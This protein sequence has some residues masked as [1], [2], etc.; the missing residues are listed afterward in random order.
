MKPTY[1]L[2]FL[3]IF[4]LLTLHVA[5]QK[6]AEVRN[7]A[8]R[9]TLFVNGQAVS[10][11][12]Y[13]L[14]HTYGGRWSWE[15]VASRN[16]HNF[17]NA[18]IRLFQVDLYFEDIWYKDS[19]S[20]DIAKVQRQVRGVLDVCP[21]AGVVIRVHV[22]APYWWNEQNP[23]ECTQYADGP[24]DQRSYG[25]PFNNEDGDTQ[26]PLRASLASMKWRNESGRRLNE[27]C[28]RLAQTPEG[29]SVIGLHVCGG[30]YG[31]WHYWGFIDHDPDTGP[32]MTSYFRQWLQQKYKTPQALQKAWNTTQ[33]TFGNATVPDSK[34]RNATTAGIFHDPAKEQRVIDY[35]ICQQEVVAEDIEYFCK[36]AKESWPRPLIVGVF[37][38]YFHM[39]FC[40]QASGGH[41][42]IERISK[43][44]YIDY[45]SAPQSYWSESRNLGG[46]GN[47]RGVIESAMLNGKLWL[48][49]IDNGFLQRSTGWDDIRV[50]TDPDSA[51]MA[52]IRRSVLYPLMRGIGFWYYDFGIQKSFGWWDRPAY[53]ANIKQ[54]QDLFRNR[55]D[56]AYTPVADVLYV[57]DQ[58]SFYYVK[59]S[60]TPICYNQ[61]DYSFE[62]LLRCG[63]IGDHV[64]LFDLPRIDL[65]R[66]KAV[67]FM[68]TFKMTAEQRQF[69]TTRVAA[70]KR[71]L[72]FNYMPGY[73]DGHVLNSDFVARLTGM[74]VSPL[75]LGQKP[76]V[77][78]INPNYTYELEAETD[79]LLE[80]VDPKSQPLAVLNGS[81]RVAC[82]RKVFPSHTVVYCVVPL[83]GSPVFRS[84]LSE[85]GCHV[86]SQTDEFIYANSGLILIHG[87]EGGLREIMLRN[88]KTVRLDLPPRCTILLNAETGEVLLQ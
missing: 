22:N 31:E 48:D 26:R 37:Y 64:Y 3:P 49:E 7:H 20:L 47:S 46:S 17:C 19:D 86:Y 62:Q 68:N 18:G 59:N 23:D 29:Q 8:G 70:D 51:Y 10:P 73:T 6:T 42:F 79:P 21:E 81:A 25:P 45:M 66:Y 41:I 39:T 16:L 52:V 57:W 55:V 83:N 50:T 76:V 30:I 65:S 56:Y 75:K 63:V 32:A 2:L 4:A 87:K 40:R 69:I 78:F 84:L 14:T 36:I 35:F 33:Y 27:F 15:E 82:A 12:F 44:P 88:G 24:V 9:P 58:E 1:S 80:I 43:C 11:S 71:T 85:A 53:L 74:K 13:A 54:E 61:L 34:E 5:A 77:Q 72:I 67:V 38:G 60:W 28:R